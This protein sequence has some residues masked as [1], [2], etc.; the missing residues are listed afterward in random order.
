MSTFLQQVRQKAAHLAKTTPKTSRRDI[1]QP[2]NFPQVVKTSYVSQPVDI[3][4]DFLQPLADP[5]TIKVEKVDFEKT[6]LPEYKGSIALV[7]DNVFS[8]EE[9]DQLINMT[10]RSAGAHADNAEI[11]N[12]GWR[13]AM[14]NAGRNREMLVL[15]YR[16]SDRII[17]DQEEVAQ[18]IWKRVVQGEGVNDSLA[19]LN[20]KLQ[21]DLLRSKRGRD[22]DQW[23][24]TEKGLNERLR[25]LK[26]GPGQYFKGM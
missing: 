11:E 24:I 15:D 6:P 26:Y 16:N 10:E 5:S 18:R 1:T 21:P 20:R 14:V 8:Q 9:C 4:E 13:P 25:F 22:G 17:W 7:L 23:L 19:V 12:S 2:R 3:P